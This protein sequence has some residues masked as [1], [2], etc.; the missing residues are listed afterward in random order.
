MKRGYLGDPWRA[1]ILRGGRTQGG[2]EGL[3]GAPLGH[4][5]FWTQLLRLP[6]CSARGRADCPGLTPGP[7]SPP[8]QEVGCL[9]PASCHGDGSCHRVWAFWPLSHPV[10]REAGG[11][12]RRHHVTSGHGS[13]CIAHLDLHS[14]LRRVL[15]LKHRPA[16]WD[17]S[18]ERP[19]PDRRRHLTWF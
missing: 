18:T 10:F 17:T 9:C 6:L 1:V 14:P 16:P 7:Q 13:A 15:G 8:G 12:G 11:P 3:S 5:L 2:R 4:L 19:R